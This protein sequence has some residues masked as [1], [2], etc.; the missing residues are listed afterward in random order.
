MDLPLSISVNCDQIYDIFM[1]YPLSINV[2]FDEIKCNI[3]LGK[4]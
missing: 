2:K 1:D 4:N 3:F